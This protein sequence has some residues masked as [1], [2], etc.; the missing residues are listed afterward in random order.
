ML[1]RTGL[2]DSRLVEMR[3]L[4]RKT[5]LMDTSQASILQ[6]KETGG[7]R[8]R[9]EHQ[10]EG[11]VLREAPDQQVAVGVVGGQSI[12]TRLAAETSDCL[13]AKPVE[14]R[15]ELRAIRV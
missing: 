8:P 14:Y 4:R 12:R 10:E 7:G 1:I 9:R 15:L 2:I 3:K 13:C 6:H 5:E 11:I